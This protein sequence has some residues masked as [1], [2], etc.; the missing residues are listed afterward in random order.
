MSP[1][2]FRVHGTFKR[3]RSGLTRIE[4]L[5]L[6]VVILVLAAV[7]WGPIKEHLERYSLSHAVETARTINTLLTQYA[8][9]NNGVYP[10]GEGTPAVGKSEGIALGLLQNSYTPDASIFSI[11]STAKYVGKASDYSD[12][13]A[14]NLSWDFTAGASATNGITSTAPDLLPT[15]FT[16]GASATYPT[17]AGTGASLP[18]SGSGPF[19]AQGVV[20]AYKGGNA[21]FIKGVTD[22]TNVVCPD[23]ITKAFQDAGPYTQIKP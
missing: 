20:V 23:F 18:L 5:I 9:D 17:A 6:I 14:A 12:L 13:A 19:E 21:L 10:V 2:P 4:L 7:S 15:V 22:G 3:G 16:T 8:T 11:G 1:F